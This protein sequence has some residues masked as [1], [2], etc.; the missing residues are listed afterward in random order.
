MAELK[1][2]PPSIEDFRIGTAP[3]VLIVAH[4]DRNEILR[5]VS[6]RMTTRRERRQ[7]EEKN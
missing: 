5:I 2:D 1:L 4:T 3:R 6:A 7:Y